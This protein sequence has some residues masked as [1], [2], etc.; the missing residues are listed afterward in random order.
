MITFGLFVTP[1]I[2]I[3]NGAEPRPLP[4]LEAT[5]A[6]ELNERPG[7]VHF[8]PARITWQ[9][10]RSQVTALR[11]QSSG[12]LAAVAKSNCFL[13]IPADRDKISAGEKVSVWLRK[14]VA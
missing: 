1:A 4:L 8:L 6:E 12:D 5:L 3:Q 14:D 9:G 7:M 10:T 13:V 2:D 11:W